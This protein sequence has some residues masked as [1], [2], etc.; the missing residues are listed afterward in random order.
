MGLSWFAI[1]IS[2]MLVT[3][4]TIHNTLQ[5]FLSIS[6]FCVYCIEIHY[7]QNCVLIG[8]VYRSSKDYIEMFIVKWSRTESL[9]HPIIPFISHSYN[10]STTPKS[11]SGNWIFF[12]SVFQTL[13]QTFQTLL[14]ATFLQIIFQIPLYWLKQKAQ[15]INERKHF[16]TT[17]NLIKRLGI[18]L[19]PLYGGKELIYQMQC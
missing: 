9:L 14:Y 4:M 10:N 2:N 3:F 6:L 19:I 8:L 1:R 11:W 5:I 16:C 15:N 13:S 12:E 17:F 18:F 7:I